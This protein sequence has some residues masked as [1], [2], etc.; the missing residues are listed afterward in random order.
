[1]PARRRG[2]LSLDR[3]GKR[4]GDEPDSADRRSMP[5]PGSDA[6]RPMGASGPAFPS[7]R[8]ATLAPG[9]YTT[10][11]FDPFADPGR[12]GRLRYTVPAGW[13]V[14][15]DQAGAFVLHHLGDAAQGPSSSDV[16]I[17]VLAQPSMAAEFAPG[18]DCATSLDAPGVGG[19]RDELAAAIRARPGIVSTPPT[20]VTFG[21]FSG[22]MLDV[23]LAPSWTGGCMSPGGRVVGTQILRAGST[24]AVVG[25]GP[26]TAIFCVCVC[27]CL[28]AWFHYVLLVLM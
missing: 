22:L 21:A 26:D 11:A 27:V 24:G 9:T 28:F 13:K 25:V 1:M 15:D 14:K 12:S 17:A 3:G 20:E 4:D 5:G 2:D 23:R 10:S 18:A 6:R 19:G 8:R 16:F 7:A